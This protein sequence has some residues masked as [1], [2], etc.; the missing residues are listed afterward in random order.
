MHTVGAVIGLTRTSEISDGEYLHAFR[1][2]RDKDSGGVRFEATP[3]R[4]PKTTIPI[5]TAFVTQYIGR[6][7]WMKRVGN[8]TIQF[9]ELHPYMFCEGYRLPRGNSGLYQLT[10]STPQGSF[11]PVK[12]H[13][14]G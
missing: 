14:D 12:S 4:G 7:S 8:S 11:R 6:R 9:R 3:R 10:F 5:W 2:F 13:A 1:I